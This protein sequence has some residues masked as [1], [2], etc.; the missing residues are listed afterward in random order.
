MAKGRG[1]RIG[2]AIHIIVGQVTAHR[3]LLGAERCQR[4]AVAL[5]LRG[6]ALDCVI[7]GCAEGFTLSRCLV[8][9]VL[10]LI[11]VAG[12]VLVVVAVAALAAATAVRVAGAEALQ[13]AASAVR[14]L[15]GHA[16][17]AV[18]GDSQLPCLVIVVQAAA[19]A[20]ARLIA[21]AAGAARAA[22]AVILH[23]VGHKALALD[24]DAFVPWRRSAG[25]GACCAARAAAR[26]YGR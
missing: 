14:L 10:L 13:A 19:R 8:L 18:D 7:G 6:R 23:G 9:F 26:L 12:K 2:Y 16:A 5:L 17:M 11:L 15:L 22:A 25:K 20:G 1:V 24:P 3:V 21:A 4:A